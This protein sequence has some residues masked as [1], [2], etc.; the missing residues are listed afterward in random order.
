MTSDLDLLLRAQD[1]DPGCDAILDTF[2]FYVELELAAGD[3][4]R[5]YPV[6]RDPPRVLPRMPDRSRRIA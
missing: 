6:E 5:V 3:P 2:V 1:G 4:A